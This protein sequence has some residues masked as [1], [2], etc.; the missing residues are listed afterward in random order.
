[1]LIGASGVNCERSGMAA[2]LDFDFR[3][4]LVR[5]P[6]SR[7]GNVIPRAVPPAPAGQLR[8]FEV[9]KSLPKSGPSP[10][11]MFRTLRGCAP[12]APRCSVYSPVT[13]G[14]RIV[15]SE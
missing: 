14:R 15:C 5:G 11:L 6:T 7:Q 2:D 10:I 3:H 8:A 1:M 9:L 13:T 4:G 12:R